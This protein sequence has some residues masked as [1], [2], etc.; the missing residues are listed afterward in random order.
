MY[1]CIY[2]YAGAIIDQQRAK[3][4]SPETFLENEICNFA[5]A[6]DPSVQNPSLILNKHKTVTTQY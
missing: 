3:T 1:V 2:L 4:E 6:I 5:R